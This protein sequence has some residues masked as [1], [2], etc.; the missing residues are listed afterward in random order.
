[1][2]DADAFLRAIIGAPDDDLP[3]L[4]Y[5]DWLDERGEG[6]RADRIRHGCNNPDARY[7]CWGDESVGLICCE[8]SPCPLCDDLHGEGVPWSLLG[9]SR[10]VVR[11]GFVAE[12]TLSWEDWTAH[13]AAILAACPI[14]RVNRR[15]ECKYCIG[16]G[17]STAVEG[18]QP[19]PTCQ[20]AGKLD[21]WR[22]DGLVRLTTWPELTRDDG[23]FDHH[24]RQRM[25]EVLWPGVRFEPSPPDIRVRPWCRRCGSPMW[26]RR[27][28]RIRDLHVPDVGQL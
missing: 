26:L 2:T 7:S 22:G 23:S 25:F 1:M 17:R 12:V 6:E 16:R 18:R 27:N 10:Y 15:T 14:R 28:Q 9:E 4:V 8:A 5:A 21:G 24:G 13:H 20:G 11:R 3:R 19:C